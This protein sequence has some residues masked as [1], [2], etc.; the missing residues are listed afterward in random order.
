[1]PDPPNFPP[2]RFGEDQFRRGGDFGSL[3]EFQWV[4]SCSNCKRELGR[5]K[6]RFDEPPYDKCPHC[7]VSFSNAKNFGWSNSGTA[8]AGLARR[9]GVLASVVTILL[10]A[11]VPL[12]VLVGV[13]VMIIYLVR[14]NTGASAAPRRA[15]RR[16]RELEPRMADHED[17]GLA[18]KRRR[19]Y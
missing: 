12:A 11:L 5:S 2:S 13:V 4:F 6:S 8:S 17:L 9:F 16:R 1:M 18:G 7:G 14:K 10:I 19:A 15:R 3:P